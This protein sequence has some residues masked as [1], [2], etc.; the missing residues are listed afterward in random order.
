MYLDLTLMCPDIGR[1]E[2]KYM[3]RHL[4][5]LYSGLKRGTVPKTKVSLIHSFGLCRGLF[6]PKAG[7][8]GAAGGIGIIKSL[9]LLV[10]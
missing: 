1:F 6:S 4:I 8:I 7:S 2:F 5:V 3:C 10:I 9:L